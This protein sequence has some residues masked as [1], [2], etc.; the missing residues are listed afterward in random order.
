MSGIDVDR[1]MSEQLKRAFAAGEP[2]VGSWVSI[3]HP[4]VAEVNAMLGFDVALIDIEHTPTTMETVQHM[5]HAIEATDGPT[6]PLVR[7]PINDPV[8]IKQVLDT[9]VSAVMVPL[10]EST[11]EARDA[12]A[13]TRYPPGGIRGI[14]GSRAAGY[15]LE[16]E[17]YVASANDRVCTVLQ[18][19]TERAVE[20]AGAIAAVDGVDALFVGP[21][22]LS[23]ALGAFGDL[24]S[25]VFRAAVDEVLTAAH[26]RDVPVGT[27]AIG[28]D[29]IRRQVEAGFD[30]MIV[31]KDAAHLAAGARDARATFEAAVGDHGS[32]SE[33]E[34]ENPEVNAD[35]D[36]A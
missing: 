18:I 36:E 32:G 23:G 2:V 27:L 14:A 15:G 25:E 34:K 28:A 24:E 20:N 1:S 16:F 26:N 9:G 22:D 30:F 17:E 11:E 29:A 13:A 31:G 5:V 19:E 33:S 21:S 12:V 35:E 4:A 3:G 8:P 10:V 7:V 6:E